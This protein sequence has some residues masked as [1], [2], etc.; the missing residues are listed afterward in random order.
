MAKAQAPRVERLALEGHETQFIGSKRVAHFAHQRVAAQARLDSD[1]IP[2][3][4]FVS[5]T[6]TS[7]VAENFSTTL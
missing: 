7:D 3:A 1:L 6:S 2:L 4:R 5:L